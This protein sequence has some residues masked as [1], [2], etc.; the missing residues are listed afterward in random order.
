MFEY[1]ISSIISDDRV[2]LS[3]LTAIT[4][5]LLALVIFVY[6]IVAP[7]SFWTGTALA[8]I[9]IGIAVGVWKLGDWCKLRQ[10]LRKAQVDMPSRA[11]GFEVVVPHDPTAR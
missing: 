4:S 6:G 2:R 10:P 1:W 11:R 7:N 9:L 5:C 3:C 8:A